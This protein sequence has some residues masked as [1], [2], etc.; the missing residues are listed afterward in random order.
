M[1]NPTLRPM[2]D[3]LKEQVDKHGFIDVGDNVEKDL[4]ISETELLVVLD[5][6]KKDGYQVHFLKTQNLGTGEEAFLR[7]LVAPGVAYR[8]TWNNRENIRL[9]DFTQQ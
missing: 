9:A 8:D 3:A 2:A 5:M 1:A 7:V 4:P 6:L